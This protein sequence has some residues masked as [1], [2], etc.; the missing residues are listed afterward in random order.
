M[1]ALGRRLAATG[2][3][4]A[5][6]QAYLAALRLDPIC[7]EALIAIARLALRSGHRSAARTALAHCIACHPTNAT[8]RLGLGHLLL[9]SGEHEAAREQ[10]AEVL[11]AQPNLASAHQ[12][13][14]RALTGLGDHEAATPHWRR[15]FGTSALSPQPYCGA[16]PGVPV[17]LL[18][19]ARGGNIPTRAL[20]DDTVFQVTALYAEFHQPGAPL[21]PHALVFNA[22]GDADL[23]GEALSNADAVARQSSAPVVNRPGLVAM[24]GRADNAARLAGLTDVIAPATRSLTRAA[25]LA[26]DNDF[27]YPLLVRAPGYHTGQHFVRVARRADLAGQIEA[28]PGDL[29]LAIDPMDAR[30][31]D[32]LSRKFRVMFIDGDIYPLHLAISHEWKVHYF[33]G[34][35]AEEAAHRADEAAFL[36]DMPGVLGARAMG[37]LAGLRDTLG[38]DYAGVDF[39]LAPDGRV[40]LFEANAGMV[41]QPP[42]P[43]PMWDYR[44]APIERALAAVKTMFLKRA[45]EAVR[46]AA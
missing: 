36:T 28:L 37:A 43:D 32:G 19:S 10:F 41:I 2:A 26:A 46:A 12:G 13:L 29:L 3:D 20:L 17:L 18:V 45:S 8:A 15:A 6:K 38:L 31:A 33:S 27:S 23:C 11:G 5:A 24:T 4:E 7:P 25:L 34:A 9:E 22:I 39:A 40:L 44:R 16:N 35:M 1:L 42:G 21:P 30:G 14:A